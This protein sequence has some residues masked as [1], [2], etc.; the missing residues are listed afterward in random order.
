MTD[1]YIPDC[2]VIVSLVLFHTA[3]QE[4]EFC[5]GQILS[6][7]RR[8]HVIIVDNGPTSTPLDHYPRDRVTFVH[9]GSN[10][11][12]GRAHNR[13]IMLGRHRAPF[14]LIMNTDVVLNGDVIDEMVTFMEKHG[15]AGLTSPLIRYP[16]GSLQTS[17]RLLP[18]P[19]NMFGRGFLDN[20]PWNREMNRSYELQHWAYDT[21][22][23]IP[24]LPGCFMLVRSDILTKV[25]G[26]DERFFLFAEDLDL[27]RRI[28]AISSCMFVPTSSIQHELRSRARFQWRR[29]LHKIV[30][31]TRYFNKWGWL[32]DRE[33]VR[34]NA[35]TIAR[36]T[37]GDNDAAAAGHDRQREGR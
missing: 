21:V 16:D 31:I 13:A 29:H 12:Y 35:D 22:Q 17:C 6:S 20:S 25:N 18:T 3:R 26:F 2:D 14:H 15:D 4:V 36:T 27:S 7:R 8:T 28:Y 9:S 11:G 19:M 37:A 32:S 24:F 23:N 34:I 1:V 10:L 33:R 5:I 30:N